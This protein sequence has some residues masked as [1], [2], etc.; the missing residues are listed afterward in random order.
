VIKGS[1][2]LYMMNCQWASPADTFD[3][4]PKVSTRFLKSSMC[5]IFLTSWRFRWIGLVYCANMAPTAL[6]HVRRHIV[7]VI[8][9]CA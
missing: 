6:G 7:S 1:K 3:S 8:F 4:A 5:M 9:N 2:K